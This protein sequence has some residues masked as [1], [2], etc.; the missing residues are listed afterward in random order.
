MERWEYRTEIITANIEDAGVREYLAQK[1]PEMVLAKF[2]PEAMQAHL[3]DLGEAGWELVAMHP[4]AGKGR[5]ADVFY[6]GEMSAYS[7]AYFCV[8]KR[9]K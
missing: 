3:D 4:I 2:A 9:R 5:N 1:Y 7:N 6:P 8:L